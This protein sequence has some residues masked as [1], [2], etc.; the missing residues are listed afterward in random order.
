MGP[1]SRV[2]LAE[3]VNV[4]PGHIS[5]VVRQALSK[6]LLVEGGLAPSK[7]GRPRI[8]LH[9]N[10]D[11][12]KL[13]GVDIRRNR[14][15][16]VVT[17]FVGRVLTQKW[18]PTEAV[19]GKDKL[20]RAVHEELKLQLAQFPN[21]AA[22]GIA[23]SAIIDPLAG[24]VILWPMVEGWDETPL[25]RIF[26][27]AYGLPTFVGNCT[28]AMA[29]TEE[30][31]GY[32]KGLRNFL[33]VSVGW[34][35]GSALFI[36]GHLY[37]GRDGLAGE[38]GHVTVEENGERCSCGNQGCLELLSSAS[39]IVR[40]VRSG[41]EQRIDSSLKRRIGERL[42]KLSIDSIISAAKSGDRLSERIVSEAGTHLGVALANVVNIINPDKIILAG[43]VPQAAGDILLNP[44]LYSLRH[45]ALRHAVKDLAVVVSQAGEEAAAVGM[46][47]AA[48]EAV[49]KARCQDMQG[50]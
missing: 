31:F 30:R 32:A 44:L 4:T 21:I 8:L 15:G 49:L 38:L 9:A 20:L 40:R 48:G 17:D 25:R 47:L 26:E 3:M 5:F 16:F 13:I 10:P 19:R 29:L 7:G 43:K 14:I 23:Q 35:I 34:G 27:D 33:L 28:H 24:D 41:L 39:A 22:I 18:L 1:L 36:D 11:F 12:A 37:N 2:D 6:G 45:R 50:E 46:A 42:D